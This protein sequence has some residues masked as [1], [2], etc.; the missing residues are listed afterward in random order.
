[1]GELVVEPHGLAET[2]AGAGDSAGKIHI[3]VQ[4]PRFAPNLQTEISGLQQRE[5]QLLNG[6]RIPVHKYTTDATENS[7]R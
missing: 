1:M 5:W 4:L 6:E 2:E 7:F 3:C